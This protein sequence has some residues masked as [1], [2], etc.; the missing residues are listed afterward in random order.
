[1][2]YLIILWP[3]GILVK[4]LTAKWREQIENES[5][6]KDSLNKAGLWIG[7]LERTLALTFILVNQFSAIGFLLAAKS[8]LRLNPS[9]VNKTRKNTE[10]VLLGTLL[11]FTVT[12]VIGLLLKGIIEVF[13]KS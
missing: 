13:Y 8:I 12:I 9:D 7:F 2:G 5:E 3:S 10:Y 4:E 11:S 6:K 1:L